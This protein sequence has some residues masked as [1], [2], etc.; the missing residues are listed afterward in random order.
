MSAADRY[1]T[2]DQALG[3]QEPLYKFSPEALEAAIQR[4]AGQD[5]A[6]A[7]D[8]AALVLRSGR[9]DADAIAPALAR[10]AVEGL[11]P[12]PKPV[13]ICN[14][15]RATVK[16]AP[17]EVLDIVTAVAKVA[18]RSAAQEI[19]TAAVSSLPHPEQMV[20]VDVQRRA[21]R[22]A[23]SDKQTDYKQ[24]DYKQL[25]AEQKQL[26]LAEAIVQAVADA[27]P[28]IDPSTLAAAANVG[29]TGGQPPFL[30]TIVPPVTPILAPGGPPPGG[31]GAVFGGPGPVSP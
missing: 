14:I 3:S 9:N 16:A 5:P 4:C 1:A 30:T 28:G 19:V 22:V 20:T 12:D 8:Y 26:T 15:V 2:L 18:P 29:F 7:G 21:D 24:Q 25:P 27:F 13:L 31:T 23:N 6:H 17:S 11:G 10:S